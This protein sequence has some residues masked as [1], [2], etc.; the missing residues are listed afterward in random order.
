ML[1]RV[2][3][4]VAPVDGGEQGAVVSSRV[5][6]VPGEQSEAIDQAVTDLG[7]RHR[8]GASGG[9]LDRQRDAVQLAADV[10]HDVDVIAELEPGTRL[11]RPH[12]EQLD[13]W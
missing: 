2:E 10:D 13:A 7:R 3:Q 9:E 5:A 12:G 4:G 11:G 1:V 6:A 8:S